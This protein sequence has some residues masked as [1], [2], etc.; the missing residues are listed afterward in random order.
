MYNKNSRLDKENNKLTVDNLFDLIL[1]KKRE[2]GSYT[3]FNYKSLKALFENYG[4]QRRFFN[5][6]DYIEIDNDKQFD[7]EES[8]KKNIKN[9]NIILSD[10]FVIVSLPEHKLKALKKQYNE[11]VYLIFND[12]IFTIIID[13]NFGYGKWFNGFDEYDQLYYKVEKEIAPQ[14]VKRTK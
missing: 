1:I 10:D 14:M 6:Y 12:L 8:I 3:S 5:V 11:D 4:K 7:F 9:N 2:E 13:L